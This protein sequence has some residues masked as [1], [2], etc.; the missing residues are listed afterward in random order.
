MSLLVR[1][2]RV[3]GFLTRHLERAFGRPVEVA[4]FSVLLLPSPQLDAD[5]ITIGED[6]AFGNEYFLRADHLTAGLRWTGLL[7]AHFE[8]GTLS[9]SR[10]SLILVRN[11]GRP[12]EPGALAASGESERAYLRPVVDHRREPA[13]A[14]RDRRRAH[15]FQSCRRK[16]GV[17]LHRRF[18]NASNK[19]PPDDGNCSWRREPWRSG[20]ALQSAGIV[21]VRGDV[22]GTSAR[23][24]PAEIHVHWERGSLADLLRLFRGRDYGVRGTFALDATAKSGTPD[25]ALASRGHAGR[26]VVL[27]AGA[28]WRKF[29]AGT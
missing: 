16:T 24:Q 4:H 29:I 28:R 8:F 22:A 7:R 25:L 23:L 19:S 26:L 3:H 11:R 20:A 2:H 5:R 17:R 10:P 18:R 21:S 1:T 15:Q 13:E 27:R 12:L 9:L 14:H 6:P